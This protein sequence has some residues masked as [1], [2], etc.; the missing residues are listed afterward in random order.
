M[1]GTNG[2]L[3]SN[4]SASIFNSKH[5]FDRFDS[6]GI[7]FGKTTDDGVK[8]QGFAGPVLTG[9]NLLSNMNRQYKSDRNVFND[10]KKEKKKS[11]R[12]LLPIKDP[13]IE[14]VD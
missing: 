13:N 14:M 8:N 1:N 9:Q 3:N 5:T 12:K 11:N 10:D 2:V 4:S 6:N 7:S